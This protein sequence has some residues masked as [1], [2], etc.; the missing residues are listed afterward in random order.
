[1]MVAVTPDY[2]NSLGS[3]SEKFLCDMADNVYGIEFTA[4]KIRSIDDETGTSTVHFEIRNDGDEATSSTSS[5]AGSGTAVVAGP[6]E[7]MREDESD[8]LREVRYKFGP[9]F[10]E[11]RMIGTELEFTCS[12]QVHNFRMIERHWFRDVCIKSYDFQL[13]FCVPHSKNTW[14][15]IYAMPEL[16]P[17]LK[18]KIRNAPWETKSDSFY[19]VGDQ[20]IMHNKAEYSFA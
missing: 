14:E 10:L 15:I 18:S 17:E 9:D 13:P 20:L 19:F 1:M 7:V 8:G 16:D 5:P 3:I 6:A 4:F 2:V 12:Q 11:L